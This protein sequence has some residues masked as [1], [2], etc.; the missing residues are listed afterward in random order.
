MLLTGVHNVHVDG[1]WVGVIHG[2]LK[3]LVAVSVLVALWGVGK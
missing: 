3:Y 2:S 1:G